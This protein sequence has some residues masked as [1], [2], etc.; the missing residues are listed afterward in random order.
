MKAV[1][2]K[3]Q[4]ALSLADRSSGTKPRRPVSPFGLTELGIH[5][6]VRTSTV[7]NDSNRF[8]DGY[9]SGFSPHNGSSV[10]ESMYIS[11]TRTRVSER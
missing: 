9:I 2:G 5:N 1:K 11:L 8:H 4:E 3:I 10:P 7:C 6:I